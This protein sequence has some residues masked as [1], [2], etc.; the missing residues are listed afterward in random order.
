L[1]A[2]ILLVRH[3]VHTQYNQCLSGRAAAVPLSEA[4][5]AQARALARYLSQDGIAR[6]E[7][8][9]LDR[10]RETAAFIAEAAGVPLVPSEALIEIDMGDWTGRAIGSFGDDPAWRAWNEQRGSARIPGGESMGEAQDRIVGH[11]AR[12]AAEQDGRT[13]ALVSHSDMIRAALAWAL[14]LGLDN[15]LRFDIDPASVS[16]LVVGEWGARVL[17]INERV[18]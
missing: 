2:T 15:L 14:G 3:A 4:G 12:I 18:H 10:T 16:R 17:S 6:V 9:P 1:A 7:C 11:I 5:R 8:S 13:V